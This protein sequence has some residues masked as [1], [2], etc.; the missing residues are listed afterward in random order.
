MFKE[1]DAPASWRCVDFISDLHLQAAEPQTFDAWSTYLRGTPANAV[2]I[3]GDLFEVWVGD[4]VLS[5][6][7]NFEAQCAQVLR[8][9]ASQRS[10]YVMH[11]NRDFL[12]GAELMRACN[13]EML[14]D[15]T[16]LQFAHRRWLLTHGDALCLDDQPYQ[17]FRSTVRSTGWQQEFL[18]KS[19]PERQSL[20]RDIR[21]KSEARKLSEARYA[22]VDSA[23]ASTWLVEAHATHMIHGHTHKPATH[24]LPDG[25]ERIV[26]SDWD[27]LATPPR[28]QVLRI[29]QNGEGHATVQR[30]PAATAAM[31]L[32]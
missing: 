22:D 32:G 1:I 25:T 29:V 23:A 16:V 24:L 27:M 2:F 13:S 31:P 30:L 19:L 9:A 26:L 4:D 15:P 17:V 21:E 6:P 20:A 11:G 3:L 8:N 7:L 28:A 18:A 10:L 14:S 5:D 12:M